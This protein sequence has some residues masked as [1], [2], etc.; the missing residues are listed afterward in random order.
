MKRLPT[1]LAIATAALVTA[2]ASNPTRIDSQWT[3]PMLKSKPLRQVLVMGITRDAATRRLFEDRMVA[4]LRAFGVTATQS[5]RF[6]P[7]EGP[8][9]NDRARAAVADSKMGHVLVSRI[10]NVTQDVR[11]SPGMVVG[12][13]WGPGWGGPPPGWGPGW[14]GFMGYQ[15]AFWGPPMAIPPSVTTTRNLHVDTRIFEAGDAHVVFAAATTTTL[16]STTVPQMVDQFVQ[17][18]VATLR[19]DSLI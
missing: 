5:Y 3:D 8:F 4:E 19:N 1:F 13:G 16:G 9:G 7:D 15:S 6:M 17:L 12:P 10:V 14:G 11:V 18:L 2:C